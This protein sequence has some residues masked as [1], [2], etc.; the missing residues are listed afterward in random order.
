MKDIYRKIAIAALLFAGLMA[1]LL[2]PYFIRNAYAS[3]LG[4]FAI[5]TAI[6][7]LSKRLDGSLKA[8]AYGCAF[9]CLILAAGVP[10]GE[11]GY[12]PCPERAYVREHVGSV[13]YFHSPFCTNCAG[14]EETISAAATKRG[15]DFFVYDIRYCKKK[16]SE[17]GFYA[18]PCFA[19]EM[20]NETV[21]A[22]GPKTEGEIGAM[23]DGLMASSAE[24]PQEHRNPE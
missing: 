7:L 5:A 11:I 9:A 24:K 15:F 4:I 12:A 13:H 2:L 6:F 20:T 1:A 10:S 3:V 16:A 21:K 19:V 14:Q 22:C 23:L 17:Y 8:V 18:T